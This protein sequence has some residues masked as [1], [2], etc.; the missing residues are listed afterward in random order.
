MDVSI[1]V[2]GGGHH[3]LSRPNSTQDS[4]DVKGPLRLWWQDTWCETH[5]F[6][7]ST[8]FAFVVWTQDGSF[9]NVKKKVLCPDFILY[10]LRRDSTKYRTLVGETTFLSKYHL[11]LNSYESNIYP[12]VSYESMRLKLP[13]VT[14]Y[15]V[16]QFYHPPG[17]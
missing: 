9:S 13:Q 10:Y 8:S 15:T 16:L 1:N 14:E 17:I 12:L 3:R 5:R 2:Q 4:N 6:E 11:L 7:T